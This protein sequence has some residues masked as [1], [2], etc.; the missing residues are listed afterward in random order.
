MHIDYSSLPAHM[1]DG[2]RR[3]IEH[4]IPP[5]H[6]LQA[7]LRNDFMEAFRRA[8]DVNTECMRDWAVFLS[9]HAPIGCY[10]SPEHV[11][12]WIKSGGL[13]GLVA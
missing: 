5:G 4:G 11:A 7:V 2:A 13:A 6:F 9:S 1:Q 10:G 3:Y 12:D 8:D